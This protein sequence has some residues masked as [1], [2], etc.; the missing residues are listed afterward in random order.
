MVFW[1]FVREFR[2]LIERVG[3]TCG[4]CLSEPQRPPKWVWFWRNAEGF[5]VFKD[6]QGRWVE[7]LNEGRRSFKRSR[8]I[9][10][11]VSAFVPLLRFRRFKVLKNSRDLCRDSNDLFRLGLEFWD[12]VFQ[13]TGG[14]S[15]TWLWFWIRLQCR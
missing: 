7:S 14:F 6:G 1:R 12:Q 3:G 4:G 9:P 2:I 13:D 10:G 15:R 5:G 8:Q 11:A